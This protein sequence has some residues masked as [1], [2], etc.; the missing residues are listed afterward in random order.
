MMRNITSLCINKNMSIAE[1]VSVLNRADAKLLLVIENGIL[2]GVVSDGDIRRRFIAAKR[3]N[4]DSI[5]SIMTCSPVVVN[6]FDK[7]KAACLMREKIIDIVPVVDDKGAPVGIYTWEDLIEQEE[8]NKNKIDVPVVIMAGGKGTRLKPYTNV[9]PKPL[10]PIGDKTII[11]RVMHSFLEYGCHRFIISVNYKKNLIKSYFE[12]MEDNNYDVLFLEEEKYLGTCGSL[13]LL[14]KINE[15][16]IVT[17]CDILLDIDYADLIEKHRANHD[18]LT[19]VT[20]RK[21]IE[22]PYGVFNLDE[23]GRLKKIIE[24]PK[25]EYNINTGV[26]AFEP[27]IVDL[28]PPN[29]PYQMNEMIQKL[30]DSNERVGAY[31][32]SDEDWSDMGQ[33]DGMNSMIQMYSSKK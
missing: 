2:I 31:L 11:E 10:I 15:T 26:Y 20:S 24:K 23:N 5:E 29:T 32:I 6:G 22:I 13:S 7:Q 3:S 33:I 8:Q 21:K 16:F 12:T 1:G 14:G 18:I 30:L 4:N 9:L 28:I 17:N 19:V 27:G 25:A